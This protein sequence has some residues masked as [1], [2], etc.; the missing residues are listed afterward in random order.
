[1][2]GW[3]GFD[4]RPRA[5]DLGVPMAAQLARYLLLTTCYLPVTTYYLPLTTYYLLLATY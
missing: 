4:E 5:V 2:S 1:M 3:P